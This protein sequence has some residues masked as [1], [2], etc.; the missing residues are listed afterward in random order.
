MVAVDPA[1]PLPPVFF[2]DSGD[3]L[4]FSS[5]QDGERFIE[6]IDVQDGVYRGWDASGQVLTF[7]E[8]V[9]PELPVRI[10]ATGAM[11]V[12]GLTDLLVERLRTVGALGHEAPSSLS[13][14]VELASTT[15]RIR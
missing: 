1:V 6:G 3:L 12:E 9:S 8:V 5:T 15:F 11:D 13:A 4:A 2:D 14:L 7:A 10:I